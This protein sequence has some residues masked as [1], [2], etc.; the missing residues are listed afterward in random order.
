MPRYRIPTT[1][2]EEVVRLHRQCLSIPSIAGRLDLTEGAVRRRVA[3]ARKRLGYTGDNRGRVKSEGPRR[4]LPGHVANDPLR[5]AFLAGGMSAS[6][7]AEGLGMRA[8]KGKFDTSAVKRSL[9]LMPE[10]GSTA[11]RR[12]MRE[13]K[14]LRFAEMLGL[15][16]REIGL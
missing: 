14:A 16:P 8:G 4:L 6:K 12:T 5:E 13:E 9:G 11:L 15:D 3:S 7:L 1:E 2:L 10:S